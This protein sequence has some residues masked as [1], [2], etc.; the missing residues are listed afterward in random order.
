VGDLGDMNRLGLWGYNFCE[1]SY[2]VFIIIIVI[3]II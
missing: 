1:Y 2:C 3:V